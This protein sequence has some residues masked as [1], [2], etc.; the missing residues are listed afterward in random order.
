MREKNRSSKKNKNRVREKRE[1]IERKREIRAQAKPETLFRKAGAPTITWE[2]KKND[3]A[4][5]RLL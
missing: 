2:N 4:N 3:I 5:L 1:I